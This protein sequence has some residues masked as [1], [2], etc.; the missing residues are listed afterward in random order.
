MITALPR[1]PLPVASAVHPA[2]CNNVPPIRFLTRVL[3]PL[4]AAALLTGGCGF[5]V[6][7]PDL[8]LLTR[9]G[10]GPSLTLLVNDGGTVRCNGGKAKPISDA[11]LIAARDLADDLGKDASAGMHLP[12]TPDSVYSFRVRLQQGTITFP[13]TAGGRHAELARA[14]Q[15]AL[16]VAQS[17]CHLGG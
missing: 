11:Q 12:A 1:G 10:Q 5:D 15:F 17:V 4:S 13:D 7:S 9:T 16:Q 6:Q 3:A 2:R 14:E 8:F